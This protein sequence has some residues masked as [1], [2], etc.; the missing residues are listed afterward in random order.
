MP[1]THDDLDAIRTIVDALTPFDTEEQK[2]IARWAFEK[3]GLTLGP[4][5]HQAPAAPVAPVA[6]AAAPHPVV[7]AAATPVA[8]SSSQDIKSFV[9]SKS[10]ANDMQ[11]AATIAYFY[12]FEALEEHKKSEIGSED[13]LEACRL[14]G[15]ERLSNPGQT[16]RNAAY[17]G[18]LDKGADK[19]TYKINT[20]GENLVALT[21]PSGAPTTKSKPPR[22]PAKKTPAKKAGK[23]AAKKAAKKLIKDK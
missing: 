1:D 18:L 19:G 13:L 12:A 5:A 22:K 23:K 3:L 11:F 16:L 2:R 15:R 8:P 14:T 17:N 9:G 21:L 6:P 10:P 4:A 20:V 7:V